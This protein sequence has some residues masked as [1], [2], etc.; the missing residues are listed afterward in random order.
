MAA[1]RERVSGR[2]E[3]SQGNDYFREHGK[4]KPLGA[5]LK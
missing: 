3:E 2:E 5:E 4:T 1:M